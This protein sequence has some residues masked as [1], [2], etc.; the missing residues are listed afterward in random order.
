LGEG[1]S[2][3]DFGDGPVGQLHDVEVVDDQQRVRQDLADRGLEHGAHVDRYRVDLLAPGRRA[4]GQ[5]A[6]DRGGGA[7][8]DLGQQSLAA[9]QIAEADVPPVRGRGPRAGQLVP[10][11]ARLPRRTSSTP[12][13]VTGSGSAGNTAVAWA[14]NAAATTGQETP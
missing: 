7:A 9:G 13:T 11:P 10:A 5:P 8:F 4:C 2:A 3:A 12:S 14:V 6:G 1:D